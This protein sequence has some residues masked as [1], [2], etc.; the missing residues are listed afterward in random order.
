M[1]S[2][3][4]RAAV[5]AAALLISTPSSEALA[6]GSTG[7]RLIGQAAVAA[8]PAEVPAF[9]RTPAAIEAIG[10][11]AR[12]PDRWRN[13]GWAHDS[14]RD[15]AHFVD[16]DDE[17]KVLGGPAL[18]QLPLT[19]AEYDAALRAV[20]S[21]SN[22]AGYLPYAIID[23]WQQLAKDFAYWRV[24]TAAVPREQNPERKAWLE[25]DLARRETL[26]INDLGVWAHYVGDASQ[27]MHV[28]V[29]YNGWGKY[30]NP[31]GYTQAHVHAAFEGEYVR[32]YVTLQKVAAAMTP[33]GPCESPIEICTARY[34]L[35]T[36]ASVEPYYALRKAGGFAADD[37][38]GQAFATTRVA[39]GAAALRDFVTTAWRASAK[40]S[41]GYPAITV[42]QAVSGAADPYGPLYGED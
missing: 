7:H 21:D 38:R 4:P 15:P 23:G 16:V 11:L 39:A 22:H 1:S 33:L 8:L 28:S 19:R 6:W 40:G 12:E 2:F 9:L 42:E 24:L 10:E 37:P 26:I 35:A 17:G 30:P 3:A 20:G 25:G 5:F 29:H 32:R 27:P 41:V 14:A 34:L 18:K 13:A 36:T 31:N